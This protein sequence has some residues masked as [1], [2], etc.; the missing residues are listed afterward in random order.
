MHST[1]L[2]RTGLRAA[3]L[4]SALLLPMTGAQAQD[5][6]LVFGNSIV[7]SPTVAYFRD[8]VVQTGAPTPIVVEY[9]LADKQTSHYVSQIGLITST[10][11]AGQT[12]RAMIVVGGTRE[13]IPGLGNPIAFQNNMLTLANAFFAHSP[14]GLFIGHETGADHPSS[15]LYPSVAPNPA[16]WLAWSHAG[17]LAAAQEITAAHPGNPAARIAPQG[18]CYASTAGYPTYLYA[19]DFHHPSTQGKVLSALLWHTA[20]YGGRIENIPVNFASSTPL[21]TRLLSNGITEP[22]WQRLV[23]LADSAQ[24]PASRPY[25]GSS[26]DFQLLSST[27]STVTNLVTRKNATANSM[28]RLQPF[29]PLGATQNAPAAVYSELLPTGT[30]PNGGTPPELW[31]NINH[32]R[33]VMQVVSLNGLPV[34][35]A[36]PPG[37]AGYTLWIQAVSRA[38][39]GGNP[40]YSDAQLVTIQ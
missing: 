13:N 36:I 5:R 28:L 20:I 30:L 2:H 39:T 25:P 12:W 38:P 16:T 32:S 31:L 27:T 24:P 23:G 22:M 1:S 3:L 37:L 17:Y 18:T 4:L 9:I 15:S 8:L 40:T 26:G 21:V 35:I 29:S 33:I 6:V 7:F 10:I 14:N 11:P 34:D 19:A